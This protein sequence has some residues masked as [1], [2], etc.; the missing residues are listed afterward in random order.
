[1]EAGGDKELRRAMPVTT[2]ALSS[3][4]P[5]VSPVSP[6]RLFLSEWGLVPFLSLLITFRA[7]SA[8]VRSET[9]C[10]MAPFQLGAVPNCAQSQHELSSKSRVNN[11]V[12]TYVSEYWIWIFCNKR[13]W[14]FYYGCEAV[15]GSI[16]GTWHGTSAVRRG[17]W[18]PL[19]GS[20]QFSGTAFPTFLLKSLCPAQWLGKQSKTSWIWT[21]VIEN[22]WSTFGAITGSFW[23]FVYLVFPR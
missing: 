16:D 15:L 7:C 5:A 21:A 19:A 18:Y 13:V 4:P 2:T 12:K 9:L 11:R 23:H 1:M 17:W 3:P 20:F 6:R 8:S 10:S 22:P 14:L